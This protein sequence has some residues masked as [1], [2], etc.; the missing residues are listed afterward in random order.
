MKTI[1][2]LFIVAMVGC[3]NV[4]IENGDGSVVVNECTNT[5]AE[6]LYGADPPGV[7]ATC[8]D[9]KP[10]TV[11]IQCTPCSAVPEEIRFIK[12]TCTPDAELSPFCFDGFDLPTRKPLYAG[13]THIFDDPTPS[14]VIDACFPVAYDL[15]SEPHAGVCNAVGVCVEN[16]ASGTITTSASE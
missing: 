16:P 2:L 4:E 5:S 12:A 10:C 7:V 3:E 6:P 13:C 15:N 1:A 9:H 14:G 8:D 11:D